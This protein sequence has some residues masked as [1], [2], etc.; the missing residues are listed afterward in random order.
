MLVLLREPI[1]MMMMSPNILQSLFQGCLL[2]LW[3]IYSNLLQEKDLVIWGW[4]LVLRKDIWCSNWT[5]YDAQGPIWALH[6]LGSP[7]LNNA[8]SHSVATVPFTAHPNF[9]RVCPQAGTQISS[10]SDV[11]VLLAMQP[12]R[13]TTPPLWEACLNSKAGQ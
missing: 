4:V 12:L 7:A 11:E 8:N 13:Q 9:N 10:S 6:N 3:H 2:S 5:E 1:I